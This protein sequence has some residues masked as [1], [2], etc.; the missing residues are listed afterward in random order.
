MDILRATPQQLLCAKP[1]TALHLDS[2]I[3]FR[4]FL[5]YMNFK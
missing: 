1:R 5:T 2:L 4:Y 3:V